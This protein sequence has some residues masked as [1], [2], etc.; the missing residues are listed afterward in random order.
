MYIARPVF[1]DKQLVA[2]TLLALAATS[3]VT[4]VLVQPDRTRAFRV[5]MLLPAPAGTGHPFYLRPVLVREA[6]LLGAAD[7]WYKRLAARSIG[8][9]RPPYPCLCA[10][11]FGI[12]GSGLVLLHDAAAALAGTGSGKTPWRLLTGAR[13]VH[14]VERTEGG[15]SHF[16]WPDYSLRFPVDVD[17]RYNVS[18]V[19]H[20]G[21]VDVGFVEPARVLESQWETLEPAWLHPLP[22]APVNIH[23]AGAE[24]TPQPQFA[25]V[26]ALKALAPFGHGQRFA[27]TDNVCLQHCLA[28]ERA[29]DAR[30]HSRLLGRP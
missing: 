3:S 22:A 1:W 10:A 23:E 6:E 29:C 30:L 15:T 25:A 4:E 5:L 12:I 19:E 17:P 9:T 18:V 8:D 2:P 24:S 27:D 26:F 21:L 13:V 20:A 14:E 28:V 16:R 11:H 7:A